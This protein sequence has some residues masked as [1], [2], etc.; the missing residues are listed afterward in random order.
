MRSL[1]AMWIALTA[2]SCAI[3][4]CSA[5]PAGGWCEPVPARPDGGS[6][7]DSGSPR[8][9]AVAPPTCARIDAGAPGLD[10]TFKGGP[11]KLDASR[12]YMLTPYALTTDSA[13]RV[14]VAGVAYTGGSP[15]EIGVARFT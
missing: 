9:G 7:A 2:V 15:S 12:I 1:P 8:D 13:G 11:V 5:A 6:V 14:L 4:A 3:A 10:P